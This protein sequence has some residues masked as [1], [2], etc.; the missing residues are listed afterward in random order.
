MRTPLCLLSLIATTVFVG[1]AQSPASQATA[2]SVRAA[3]TAQPGAPPS[4]RLQVR[5]VVLY[6][7]G[8]GYFE[9][10]G[11]VVGNQDVTIAFNSAQL[12]DALKSLVA[13]DLDDGIVAGVS[14]NST[15]P[16][17]QRLGGVGVRLSN[18][19]NVRGFFAALQG[20]RVEI[21]SGSETASGRLLSVESVTRENRDAATLLSVIDER[22]SVRSL[23][24]TSAS[25]V[26]LLDADLAGRVGD[27][28]AVMAAEHRRDERRV[29]IASRG[30]GTRNLFVSYTSEVP[31]W[32]ATYRLLMPDATRPTPLLQGWAI[33]D[34]TVGEDWTAVE[35]ALVAGAPQSF[36]LRL[37]QPSYIRRPAVATPADEL[38]LPQTHGGVLDADATLRGVARDD[39]GA[40]LPGVTVSLIDTDDDEVDSV[41]TDA[42]GEYS[43]TP[44]AGRYRLRFE[45]T[46]FAPV[47]SDLVDAVP[48]MTTQ[49]DV[50]MAVAALTETVTVTGESTIIDTSSAAV[51]R[52][53]ASLTPMAVARDIGD[54]FEYRIKEPVT[55]PRNQSALVP[56]LQSPIEAERVSIWNDA[57]G[58]GRP[59]RAVWIT[60]SSA[61]TLD[62]GTFT[63]L[64]GGVF[65]GEG[66]LQSI[67]PGARRLL[68]YARDLGTL[69][70]PK[71]GEDRRRLVRLRAA[72]GLFVEQ[73]ETCSRRTYTLRNDDVTPRTIVVEHPARVQWSIVG[74]VKPTESVG[75]V[76]RFAI[77]VA[78]RSS[79]SLVVNEVNLGESKVSVGELTRERVD[80]YVRDLV[81]AGTSMEG[82]QDV[83]ERR[84]AAY[85]LAEQRGAREHE[86]RRIRE[87]QKRL[88]ENIGALKSSAEERRLVQRYVGQLDEQED[89]LERLTGEIAALRTRE[90]EA[91]V[92]LDRTVK[93]LALEA[94]AAP[95]ASCVASR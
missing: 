32:K 37:S 20:A 84:S 57:V 16:L 50:S 29:T 71:E 42:R 4:G 41:V 22:G 51:S 95:G 14:Y 75:S 17:Q 63:V 68:S 27:Y 34:N 28:L 24:V 59:L 26:R 1:H 58:A 92:E 73:H 3:S 88:R 7:N 93:A 35:L 61:L 6:K 77:G 94:S 70:E 53:M 15:A 76:H 89:R 36:V 78:P 31:V 81:V 67:K 19:S 10:L 66:L 2:D 5:R 65:A 64:D 44:D 8:V 39:S 62:A 72:S 38:P 40:V 54:L 11:Q 82:L 55:I 83:L 18:L 48:G 86:V 80:A 46:G 60:N 69:V 25:A 33:V 91:A 43:F 45:L 30:T 56:I 21:R 13:L 52:R 74:D 49:Q 12:D 90:Q 47:V 87:E 9:H 23:E 79:T 85:A